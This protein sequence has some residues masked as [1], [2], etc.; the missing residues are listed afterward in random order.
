MLH[1]SK[2]G[3]GTV[4]LGLPYGL[5]SPT[6]P[7]D[8]EAETI[9]KSALEIGITYFDTA[10]AYG[11]AEERLGKFGIST[12]PG[13]TVGTKCGQFLKKEPDISSEEL[14]KRIRQEID[15]S[16]R[17]LK[18]D[19]LSLVQFHLE[20]PDFNRLPELTEIALKL[21]EEGIVEYFGIAGRGEPVPLATIQTGQYASIQCAYSI[22]DQRMNSKVLPSAQ[23]KNI[24]VINRS[25]LLKGALTGKRNSLPPQLSPLLENANKAETIAQELGV[26]LPD[27]AIRFA[28]SNPAITTILIGTVKPE[29]LASATKAIEAG[30]L[31]EEILQKLYKLAIQNP[32]QI[33]PALWPQ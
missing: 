5:S 2:L 22:L 1:L 9:L 32:N 24:A 18:L 4:E 16:R 14:E 29:H 21:K 26:T 27:L 20:S 7:S 6:L 12:A 28:A 17:N 31:S 11:L 10:R 13:V 3:L 15:E 25:V 30:P 8:K 33:D 19:T 23:E